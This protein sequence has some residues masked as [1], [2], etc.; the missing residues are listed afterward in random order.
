[1]DSKVSKFSKKKWM[2]LSGDLVSLETPLI[3][4]ILNTTPDSFYD[5]GKHV[6]IDSALA[7][8]E[9]M[10]EEGA[11]IIDIGGYSS[12]P[13]AED[14]DEAS[15]IKRMS[16]ILKAVTRRFPQIPVSIDTFRS[17]VAR[18][19]VS[20]GATMIND[21]SGGMSD[22]DMFN[23]V[24]ELNVP[25]VLMHMQGNPG[26]MQNDPQYENVVTD[27]ASFFAERLKILKEIGVNDVILD[28]GFGFGKSLYHNYQLMNNL[29]Y[30]THLGYPIMIGVSRKSMINKVLNTKPENAAN[31]STVLHTYA[32]L[33]GANIIRTH[34]VKM[35][36]ETVKIVM[37]LQKS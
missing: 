7:H 14:I 35:A 37:Q 24:A 20:I 13:G 22:P 21:I 25:Y 5:G 34:D 4:G 8:T 31:G 1:M 26:N 2:V 16:P 6:T 9:K 11:D 15:E 27:V 28:P 19:A 18:E 17:G 3:M 30:F 23:T 10:I 12:R 36:K 29:E 33:H 32:L